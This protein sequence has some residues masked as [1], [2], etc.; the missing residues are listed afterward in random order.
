M[1]SSGSAKEAL[2]GREHLIL[3]R[4]VEE[5]STRR[6]RASLKSPVVKNL[7]ANAGDVGDV[8]LISGWGRSPGGGIGN[9]LQYSLLENPMDRGA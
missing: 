6:H 1:Q 9:P 5:E 2:W 8:G 4:K 3:V 7:P